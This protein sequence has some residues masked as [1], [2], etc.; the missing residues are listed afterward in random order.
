MAHG[1]GDVDGFG[2]QQSAR[3]NVDL[4]ISSLR[5]MYMKKLP[6]ALEESH[7]TENWNQCACADTCRSVT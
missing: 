2:H 3:G 4:I 1:A 6:N 5:M 7:I